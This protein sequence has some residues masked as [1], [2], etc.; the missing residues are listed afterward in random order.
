M[1]ANREVAYL[2]RAALKDVL[3]AWAARG[4][5]ESRRPEPECLLDAASKLQTALDCLGDEPS[6]T[7]AT[8]NDADSIRGMASALQSKARPH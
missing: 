5:A 2:V 7:P 8:T 3:E 4:P 1:S 6:P